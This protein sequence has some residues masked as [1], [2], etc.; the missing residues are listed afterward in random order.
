MNYFL[1]SILSLF[2]VLNISCAHRG[3]AIE[4]QIVEWNE[5]LKNKDIVGFYDPNTEELVWSKDE[6]VQ[7]KIASKEIGKEKRKKLQRDL[8]SSNSEIPILF[9]P[10]GNYEIYQGLI[11]LYSDDDIYRGNKTNSQYLNY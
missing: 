2:V 7:Q 4:D 10:S 3:L 5:N 1:V 6:I 9:R 11:I 8:A